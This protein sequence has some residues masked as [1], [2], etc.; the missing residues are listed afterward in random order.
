MMGHGSFDRREER[1][2][3]VAE[4]ERVA[5][6][7]RRRFTVDEFARM[8]EAGIFTEDDRVELIDGEILEMTP[9]GPSHAWIVNR[10]TELFMTQLGS[11]AYVSIRNPIRLGRD[12]EPQPDLVVAR[13]SGA[14]ARRHP[15]PGDVLLVVEAA[16]SS[17]RHDRLEK[18]PRY[19]R[20][21]VPETWLVDVAAGAVTAY[22]DPGPGGYAAERVL[23]PGDVL[24]ATGVPALR[25]PVAAIFG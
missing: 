12:T 17:L 14:Y 8:G 18:I 25:V 23:R 11:S 4:R 2:V 19:G 15:E 21:G 3:A 13:R 24:A 20:A 10:L 22:T 9:V 5:N 6:V 7:P 16:D 1:G